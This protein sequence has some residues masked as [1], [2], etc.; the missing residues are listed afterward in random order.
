M[1]EGADRYDFTCALRSRN[2]RHSW[3]VDSA[4]SLQQA[5]M[6]R[7]EERESIE[8]V[9]VVHLGAFGQTGGRIARD[10]QADQHRIHV[11]LIAVRSSATAEAP[12]VGEARVDRSVQ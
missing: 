9:L 6:S 4:M 1:R 10:D 8:V 11:H 7:R 3:H 5:L 12:T 2:V